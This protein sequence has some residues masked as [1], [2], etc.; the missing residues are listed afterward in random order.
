MG[1]SGAGNKTRKYRE[2]S[3]PI[4]QPLVN[5][6]SRVRYHIHTNMLSAR[7]GCVQP[8]FYQGG[9]GVGGEL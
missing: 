8:R 2:I 1:R 5:L 4:V 6:T 9:G 3:Y 7:E